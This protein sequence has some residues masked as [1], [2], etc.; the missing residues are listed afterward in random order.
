[1]MNKNWFLLEEEV[2]GTTSDMSWMS[3]ERGD[4]ALFKPDESGDDY[5]TNFSKNS[6]TS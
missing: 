1:M 2:I 3:N 4:K 6:P 5:L